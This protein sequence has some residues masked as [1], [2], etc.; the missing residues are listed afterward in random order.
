M[1]PSLGVR[2]QLILLMV[3]VFFFFFVV[4]LIVNDGNILTDRTNERKYLQR[5][6]N[7]L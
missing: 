3:I 5:K 7:D 1:E 6:Y 2:G 4:L